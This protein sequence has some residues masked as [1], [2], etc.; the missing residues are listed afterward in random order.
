VAGAVSADWFAAAL[1]AAPIC[2]GGGRQVFAGFERAA[3]A[4]CS[5]DA[6]GN[7]TARIAP[8][9][10]AINP[11]PWYGFVVVGPAGAETLVELHYENGKHR[12]APR[13]AVPGGR[14]ELL[15]PERLRLSQAGSVATL[16]LPP[17]GGTQLL[18]AQPPETVAG[19]LAPFEARVRAGQLVRRDAGY[20]V[21]RRPLAVYATRPPGARGTIVLVTRQHPPETTGPE[22]FATFTDVLLDDTPQARAFRR[23]VALLIV[24]LANPDGF[25]HGH[26]RHNRGGVDLNR[27]WG[28]FT[29]PETRALGAHIGAATPVLAL[30]DFHST[31][32]DVIYAPPQGRIGADIGEDVLK[33]IAAP[34]Q[35]AG[36]RIDRQHVAGSGVL[37]GWAL[38]AFGVGALTWEVGDSSAPERTAALART[39][40]EA[41]M[42]SV[43]ARAD[44]APA[45]HGKP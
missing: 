40:A 34:L 8:E 30:I 23:D 43:A 12:Y 24:P 20:S 26:W 45:D 27:D 31:F 17:G 42:A 14:A 2:E 15:A 1:A 6:R 41:L 13:L 19:V 39:A 16:A 33:R 36:V 32:R 29:Q 21:E 38:D 4:G 22:A 10:P 44:Q 9:S 35:D 7:V 18:I 37:K 28:P 25:V 3:L 11:S 5:I